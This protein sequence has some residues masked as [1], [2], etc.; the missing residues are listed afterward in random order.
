[1]YL[2]FKADDSE[3][4]FG[5]INYDKVIPG[6]KFH[7]YAVPLIQGNYWEVPAKYLMIGDKT[8]DISSDT[9][10]VDSGTSVL[11]LYPSTYTAVE[12]YL[13]ANV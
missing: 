10:I 11:C 6:S 3:V 5:G 8:F 1:M 7:Y 12:E 2:G 13:K 9:T 4:V